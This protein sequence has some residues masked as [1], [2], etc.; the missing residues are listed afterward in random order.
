MTDEEL[1]AKFDDNAS[2]F[3][4]PEQRDRLALEID[5]LENLPNATRLLHACG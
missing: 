3:L 2:G 4:S 1:R 5:G